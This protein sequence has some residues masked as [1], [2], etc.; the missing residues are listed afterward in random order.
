M[1]KKPQLQLP[2]EYLIG[3]T[4][5]PGPA[6]AK[7]MIKQ[8]KQ[9]IKK[10]VIALL[11][12]FL[13]TFFM[14]MFFRNLWDTPKNF[15][16]LAG[17]FLILIFSYHLAGGFKKVHHVAKEIVD[18][19]TYPVKLFTYLIVLEF[20]LGGIIWAITFAGYLFTPWWFLFL[21]IIKHVKV[22]NAAERYLVKNGKA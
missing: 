7:E 2:E 21:L 8:R 18:I 16:F 19:I 9:A 17:Y 1:A 20:L 12:S 14:I 13:C 6:F 3:K 5:I 4:F 15:L 10:T 11:L 22:L